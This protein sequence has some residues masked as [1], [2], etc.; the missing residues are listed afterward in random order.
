MICFIKRNVFKLILFINA[1]L[2]LVSCVRSSRLDYSLNFAGSNRWELERVLKHYTDSGLKYQAAC[3]LIENM[4]FYH[5]YKGWQIDS[6]KEIKKKSIVGGRIS[7]QLIEQWSIFSFTNLPKVYDAHIIKAELLIN[8]IDLAFQI[9]EKRPWGQYYSFEDFCEYILPYRILD[10][11]LEEWREIYYNKYAFLLDS[12]YQ[13]NDVVEAA[14]VIAKHLKEEGFANRTDFNLPHLGSLY[15]FEN[16]VGYCR[17]NCDIVIY[18]MRSLGI[19]VATDKYIVSPTYNSRHFWS[20]IIDTTGL[21]VSF[22]YTENE[23]RRGVHDDRKKGKIYRDYFGVQKEEYKG[24]YDDPEIPILF[25]TPFMKDVSNQYFPYTEVEVALDCKSKERFVYLSIFSNRTF[26]P[27]DIAEVRNGKAI[28]VNVEEELIYQPVYCKRNSVIPAGFPFMLKDNKTWNF[29]PDTL[30]RGN[31]H[32]TRKYPMRNN[33]RFLE[34]AVG[35]KIEGANFQDFRDAQLLHQVIDTPKVNYNIITPTSKLPRRY[36]KYTA[37]KKEKIELAE[38]AFF[39]DTLTKEQYFPIKIYSQQQLSTVHQSTLKLIVDNDWAS[40]YRSEFTGESLIVDFGESKRIEQIILIPR[41]D[42]NF[43]HLGDEYELFYQ[44]GTKGWVSLGK[45]V[46]EK[47]YLEYFNVPQNA[48][49]WL[50][51]HTRG[52]EERSFYYKNNTQVFP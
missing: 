9:W 34:T 38:L 19:P 35:V 52:K 31:V 5:T 16:R 22:N 6:L 3:F 26:V 45:K 13:G 44:N 32:L 25:K 47:S 43:I 15:L 7:N 41:N 18:V 1:F 49:F 36:V 4:P 27:I 37:P 30:Q 20:A 29:I 50:C 2:L 46:A 48:L 12:V 51:N 40:F 10:E 14:K 8:N 24:L 28:F 33:L 42:D 21:A 39:G 11:P 23:M 17:E